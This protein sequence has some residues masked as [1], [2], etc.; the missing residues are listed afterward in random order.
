MVASSSGYLGVRISETRKWIW[1]VNVADVRNE[2]VRQ[3]SEETGN[4]L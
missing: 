2:F 1:Q 4:Q 3:V